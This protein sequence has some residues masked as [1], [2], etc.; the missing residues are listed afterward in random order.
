MT[1][2]PQN[3]AKNTSQIS[4]RKIPELLA[5]AGNREQLDAALRYGADAVYLG[6]SSLNLR[7]GSRGFDG[8]A[9]QQAVADAHTVGAKVYYCLNVLPQQRHMA[10]MEACL[11]A[12]PEYGVDGLIVA[13]PGVIWLTRRYCPDI[14]L[15]LSTQ[16][17]TANAYAVAFWKELGFSRVNLARELDCRSIAQMVR[18][19]PDME[20]EAFVHGAQ[21]LALSGRCLLSAWL[22]GRS[23]NLGRCTHP[24]RFEYQAEISQSQAEV[25]QNGACSCQDPSQEINA[26][27]YPPSTETFA[28]AAERMPH[29]ADGMPSLAVH[30]QTRPNQTTWEVTQDNDGF[31]EGYSTFWA[32]QDLALV[33]FMNWYANTGIAAVKVEGRVK[34]GSYVAQVVD[35]YRT[36]LN[37]AAIY[38][39]RNKEYINELLHTASRPLSTGFFLP[40]KKR[41]TWPQPPLGSSPHIVALING[42]AEGPLPSLGGNSAYEITVKSPWDASMPATLLATGMRR[43]VMMPGDYQLENHRGQKVDKLHPGMRG[44][45]HCDMEGLEKGLY[46]RA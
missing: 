26:E 30:E 13:D 4:P 33:R 24:C 10:A 28:Y 46:I 5:P 32:P 1:L 40:S 37:D 2:L 34:T 18:H 12:I 31:T 41:Y 14:P 42:K 8:E 45:L 21:C 7:A 19:S 35:V 9:L 25:S 11:E 6:G 39:H 43:P 15:H 3:I 36:A 20:F 22:N 16:A 29:L 17:N 44:I 27:G 23:A 38:A